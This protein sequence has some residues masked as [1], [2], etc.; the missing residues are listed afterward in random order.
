MINRQ[1]KIASYVLLA[2]ASLAIMTSSPMT[3]SVSADT[4]QKSTGIQT[5]TK[6]YD[7]GIVLGTGQGYSVNND[8]S[9]GGASF[10][11]TSRRGD[12]LLLTNKVDTIGG[13]SY[14]MVNSG[15]M[16][17]YVNTKDIVIPK[18]AP[19]I[20][21]PDDDTP[22]VSSKFNVNDNVIIK[23][24]DDNVAVRGAT[25]RVTAKQQL[26]GEGSPFT[27]TV[28]TATGQVIN[29]VLEQNLGVSPYS[30][31]VPR[32]KDMVIDGN[33]GVTLYKTAPKGV[34]GSVA[35]Q[36]A[37]GFANTK[38]HIIREVRTTSD[39]QVWDLVTLNGQNYFIPASALKDYVAPVSKYQVGNSVT[40]RHIATGSATGQNISSLQGQVVT[41]VSETPLDY[42]SSHY[43]YSVKTA[44]GQ[45]IDN[46][47]EQDLIPNIYSSVQNI[48]KDV[49]ISSS[50]D[51]GL[52]ANAP[53][54]EDGNS[55]QFSSR[56]IAGQRVHAKQRVTTAQNGY[57]WYLV[58]VNGQDLYIDV[59]GASD[60]VRPASKYQVGQTYAISS[61]ATGAF[62][63][64]NISNLQN[65]AV[66]ILQVMP[67][68]YSVSLYMYQV[69]T[70]DGHVYN[71]I[72]EQD[73][74]SL[75]SS[76]Y[77]ANDTVYIASGASATS[78]GADL[79]SKRGISGQ[80]IAKRF[81]PASYS[82]WQYTIKL[83]DNSTVVNVLEQD[84]SRNQQYKVNMDKAIDWFEQRKGKLTY[85]MYGSRNGNDG[86]ADCSGSVTQA[87]RDAGASQY[88]WL[89]NTEYIHDY[90]TAN[91][92][93]LIN[94]NSPQGWDA[95]R[96]DIVIWGQRGASA[97]AG[98]HIGIMTS[99][100]DDPYF[101]STCYLTRG[102]QG[103]AV[104]EV[105]YNEFVQR[106]NYPYY[107]VYRQVQ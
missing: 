97:G 5:N 44:S 67:V 75:P 58:T 106:D 98:G 84:L 45:Q 69:A 64:S 103:T 17:Y 38:V 10:D 6:M 25:G 82:K 66:K 76:G 87:L 71:N 42:G 52:Y 14:Y 47:A 35:Y 56:K 26:S 89:Y 90:L 41:I 99:A 95:K 11:M 65:Q 62:G 68:D 92:F 80:I 59:N 39:S 54:N 86:T 37:S 16:R 8:S 9:V 46:I 31:D 83:S 13:E 61:G 104:Q 34:D 12:R 29:N 70:T 28:T 74:T 48:D 30:S 81:A 43:V 51:D 20:S 53:W 73:I 27:Y 100:D 2:S 107:Y 85:S 23:Q 50:R 102:Q 63:G 22:T 72:L 96:G 32:D 4:V 57:S 19:P 49:V 94:E 55:Y 7:Y 79:V 78:T 40:V 88:T 3:P 36:L 15:I 24:T 101:I 93:K 105:H 60:Y 33:S 1:S 18:V 21:M 91:G 77:N